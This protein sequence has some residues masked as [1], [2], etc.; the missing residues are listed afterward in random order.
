MTPH[1]PDPAHVRDAIDPP[2]SVRQAQRFLELVDLISAENAA[3]L[4]DMGERYFRRMV[5]RQAEHQLL[6]EE[7]IRR[8]GPSAAPNEAE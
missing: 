8:L 5:I 3:R 1:E 7:H 6:Y 4:D 2:D